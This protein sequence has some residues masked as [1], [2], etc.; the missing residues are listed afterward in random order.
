[1]SVLFAIC[2][3]ACEFGSRPVALAFRRGA[4]EELHDEISAGDFEVKEKC[5]KREGTHSAK[6]DVS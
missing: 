6:Y 3:S 5:K 1:M 4:R 2:V